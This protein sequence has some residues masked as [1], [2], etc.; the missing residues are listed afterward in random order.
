MRSFLAL[1][2]LALV[3]G[4]TMATHRELDELYG[5]PDPARYEEAG[6]SVA[7]RPSSPEA[8]AARTAWEKAETVFE[9]RCAVCHACYDA[10][11]QLKLTSYEGVTRGA[12]KDKVYAL[13]VMAA[14]PTR[15]GID[16]QTD[17]EWRGKGFHAVLNERA[18]SVEADRNASVMHRLLDLKRRHAPESGILPSDR[19]DF[20]LDRAQACTTIEEVAEIEQKKPE[21]GMPYGM[22]QLTDAEYRTLTEW[23]TAGAPYAS[24]APLSPAYTERV[25]SW[26]TL[27]NGDGLKE[28]LVSRYLYEHWY[29]AHFYFEDLPRGGYFEMVR[30]STP[31][32]SPVEIIPSVRPYDDP[33]VPRVYYRLRRVEEA[34]VTKT[35]MPYALSPARMRWV[36]KL[37]FEPPY[38]VTSLPS[39]DA[40]VASNPFVTFRQLPVRSRY[41]LMLEEAQYTIMGFIKGP[42]C[43]GQVALNV[44]NDLFWVVFVDPELEGSELSAEELAS[45]LEQIHLPAEEADSLP[46]VQWKKY[47][48]S[49][50]AYL[51][52]KYDVMNREF[53]GKRLPN[54]AMLWDGDGRNDNAALTIFRHFDSATV[55]R[56][57]VGETPQTAWIVGY[58]LLERIHYLLVA[59]YD[60]YGTAGHQVTTRMYMDFLRMEGEAN[61]LT[62]LPMDARDGVRDHWYRRV[63]ND[64]KEYL[65]GS[66]TFFAH[67]TGVKYRTAEPLPELYGL[68]RK[69]FSRVLSHRYDLTTRG[70]APSVRDSLRRLDAL[71]GAGTAVL[72]E[73]S[74]LTVTGLDGGERHFTLLHNSAHSN[75]STLFEEAKNRL[76][77]EDTTTLTDGFLGA[78]PNVF[79]EV[80]AKDLPSFVDAVAGLKNEADYAALMSRYG[81]RRTD[82]RF[83][84]HSDSLHAAYR[85]SAPIEAG[86]FD[87]SRYE[88]R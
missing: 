44:I 13:R 15:L 46:L 69:Q 14:A 48:D 51:K 71:S 76:P 4:C 29:L 83:W 49:E 38:E 61:F 47:A 62:L 26:E 87:Y 10:P 36:R 84:A 81:V 21:L 18:A 66:K 45:A 50:N 1:T 30:S 60:V 33:G 68:L 58:S 72:P 63:G 23:I 88:N 27:L 55:V 41:R 57:L 73:V 8:T 79:H 3:A 65:D 78:Y 53:G 37:F 5:Q 6:R 34:I 39:Y 85:S 32:G 40:H 19:Y 43:R 2:I 28:Q 20:S 9:N 75:I 77:D 52:A 7:S 16:A 74:F 86:I 42:V 17:T 25:K 24:P 59:G 67:D 54:L 56:G 22:P 12:S 35:H 82:A 64:V 11:C 31:P 70:L 80:R